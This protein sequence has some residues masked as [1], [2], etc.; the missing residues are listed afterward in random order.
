[1]RLLFV[2]QRYGKE[3][4]GG[5]ETACR[6]VATRLASRGHEVHVLTSCALS[7]V[8]WANVLPAGPTEIDGVAVHRLAVS[9][10]REDRFFGPMHARTVFGRKPHPLFLQEEWMRMEGPEVRELPQ[11]LARR[12]AGFDAVVF[13]TYLYYTT[14]AGLPVASGLTPTVLV[15]TAHDEPPIYLPLFDFT[16]RLPTA[17]GFLSEE[18][19]QLV[20]RRFH[21]DRPS[22]ITALGVDLDV[23]GDAPAFRSRYQLGD[24]PYV[25]YVGR[26]DPGKGSDELYGYFVAYK[27][28]NPGPLA[29]VVV[30]DPVKPLAAHRDVVCTG[31]VDEATKWGAIAGSSALIQPSYYE[32][33]SLALAEAWVQQKPCLVQGCCEVLV[34]Q[35]RRSQG[36]IPYFGFAEFEA[37]LDLLLAEPRLGRQL[38]LA[39]RAYVERHYSWEAVLDK[40][41]YLFATAARLFPRA[42]SSAAS[43]A[44]ARHAPG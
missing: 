5:S 9:R 2:V 40:Y 6:Q 36:A 42:T 7:Y 19:R 23:A 15:P 12:A 14:W 20:L 24:R 31:Y 32:S 41:E 25:V 38:G 1:M 39:G 8:D 17:F 22:S 3:V 13:F 10:P 18:E 4:A 21:V 34:G 35:A 26:L 43:F 28:R 33:F 37:G 29:L 11:W 44:W 27:R 30:G 16:F